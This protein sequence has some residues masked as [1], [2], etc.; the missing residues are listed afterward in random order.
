M[1]PVLRLSAERLW[2]M[3]ELIARIADDLKLTAAER[4]QEIPS[5]GQPLIYNRVHW[6]KTY[7]KKAGLLDQPK[8][9]TVQISERGKE[10]LS[11]NPDA[12]DVQQL[13]GF[14]EFQAF[15]NKAKP[16]GK[17]TGIQAAVPLSASTS[18][19]EEQ[20]EAA[21]GALNEFTAGRAVG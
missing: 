20:L 21:W 9:G 15:L 16:K 18:T 1:L 4:E 8:Y 13:L 14:P 12:I 2:T 11:S 10:L 3:R 7:L 5:G 6:A 19:P 17:P